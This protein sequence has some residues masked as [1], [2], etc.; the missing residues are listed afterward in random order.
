MDLAR[1]MVLLVAVALMA[2]MLVAGTALAAPGGNFKGNGQGVGG[3]NFVNPDNG[4]HTATG[5][6]Q[7]NNPNL[8][9][10]C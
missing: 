5:G 9:D 2:V 6:G 4:K 3:G 8:C 10:V 7:L 1:R